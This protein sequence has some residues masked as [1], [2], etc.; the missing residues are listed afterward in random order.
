M[1]RR[2]LIHV[3]RDIFGI[4]VDTSETRSSLQ[5]ARNFCLKLIVYKI[6]I[7]GLLVNSTLLHRNQENVTDFLPYSDMWD[8]LTSF[9]ESRQN[10]WRCD[11]HIPGRKEG[12]MDEN[13]IN[14]AN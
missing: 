10:Y 7:N 2:V 13:E 14:C 6:V 8:R 1:L 9:G 12:L 3:V 5:Q 11:A 4:H